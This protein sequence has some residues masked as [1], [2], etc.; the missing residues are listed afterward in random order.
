MTAS[1]ETEILLAEI[2]SGLNP[3][4]DLQKAP[5]FTQIVEHNGKRYR[6]RRPPLYTAQWEAL[7]LCPDLNG[8]TARF[9]LCEASTKAG[10]TVGCMAWLAEQA[11]L[12]VGAGREYWW[13]APVYAQAKIAYSRMKRALKPWMIK[14]TNDTDNVIV[15]FHDAVMRFRSAEKPDNLY[16]DDVYAVVIDE[17]SRMREAAFFAI[18]STLTATRGPVRIIGNVKGRGNWFYKM[19]RKAQMGAPDM[20]YRKITAWDAAKGGVISFDEVRQAK[21]MLPDAVFL[22]LYLAEGS[23]DGENP[24][25]IANIQRCIMPSLSEEKTVVFGVDLGDTRDYTVVVGL[26]RF[27]DMTGIERW[28]KT[29]WPFTQERVTQIIGRRPALVDS[30]GLGSVVVQNIVAKA[31]RAEGYLF[32]MKSKQHLMEGLA[33]AIQGGLIGIVKEGA[34]Q[35]LVEELEIFEFEHT[36]TGTR[37]TAPEGFHDDCVMALALAQEQYRR[38]YPTGVKRVAPAGIVRAVPW[39]G[40]AQEGYGNG[41]E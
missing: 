41:N 17:A 27:G 1:P 24:F 8:R 39:F 4:G 19:S 28:N 34:G 38:L 36:R 31:S 29:G 2:D 5:E 30:T 25:G 32:S 26:D 40:V 35:H 18:R 13:V 22:E 6:W 15:L 7:F 12:G 33:N 37:Y 16:G 20:S 3:P 14:S 21:S 11:V 9:G 23:E 10:K